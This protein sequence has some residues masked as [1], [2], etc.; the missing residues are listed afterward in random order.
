MFLLI[1]NVFNGPFL[2]SFIYNVFSWPFPTELLKLGIVGV[3]E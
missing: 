2:T 1:Y 3:K